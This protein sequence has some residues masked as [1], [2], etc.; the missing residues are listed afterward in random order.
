MGNKSSDEGYKGLGLGSHTGTTDGVTQGEVTSARGL[1]IT[2]IG[3]TGAEPIVRDATNGAKRPGVVST[4]SAMRGATD[5]SSIGIAGTNTVEPSPA[6]DLERSDQ[7]AKKRGDFGGSA[8]VATTESGDY[9]E[10]GGGMGGTAD[11]ETAAEDAW[12]DTPSPRPDDK[13]SEG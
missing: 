9:T 6:D 13:V 7:I 3:T 4:S 8:G 1:G 10:L 12:S 2:D 5:I 11:S